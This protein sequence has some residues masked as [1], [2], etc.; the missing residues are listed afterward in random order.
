LPDP[1]QSYDFRRNEEPQEAVPLANA[2]GDVDYQ[3][4]FEAD[5][6][7][8]KARS[9][10]PAS[11]EVSGQRSAPIASRTT[12][13]LANFHPGKPTPLPDPASSYDFRK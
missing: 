13:D 2:A 11:R 1:A 4:M 12:V 3:A 7:A 9:R 5:A 6:R 10:N 8:R